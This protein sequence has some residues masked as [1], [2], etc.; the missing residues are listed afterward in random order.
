[1]I[2]YAG[3]DKDPDFDL[4]KNLIANLGDDFISY[5][6]SPRKQTLADLS[7]PPSL[8]LI[9]SPKAEQL[10]GAIK[11]LSSFLPQQSKLKEREF[12]GRKVYSMGLPGG[13]GGRGRVKPADTTLSYAAS[14]GYLAL[15]T[16]AAMLEE[17]LRGRM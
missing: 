11:A 10:A 17:F 16:D 14:G 5:Q 15:S 8:F 2:D 9:S 12:L 6:K 3:K 1:M 4:R 13:G 7:S